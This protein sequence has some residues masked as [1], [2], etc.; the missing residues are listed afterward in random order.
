M[1]FTDAKRIAAVLKSHKP[2]PESGT[3]GEKLLWA[4]LVK[5]MREACYEAVSGRNYAAWN[6]DQWNTASG[7]EG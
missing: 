4:R 1:T 5:T 6:E 2:D 3:V 7:W